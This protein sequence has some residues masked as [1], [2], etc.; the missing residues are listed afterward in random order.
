MRT[1][2]LAITSC[3]LAAACASAGSARDT[4]PASS[5]VR[6]RED[7]PARSQEAY[8]YVATRPHVV[9]ALAE[10][11]GIDDSSAHRMVDDLASRVS[12]CF[13]ALASRGELAEGAARIVL[14]AGPEGGVGG[15][16][17]RLAPGDAVT[18]NALLCV[19][20]AVK[21]VPLPAP[22][23]EAKVGMALELTWGRTTTPDP[24]G[25]AAPTTT[26]ED[27]AAEPLAP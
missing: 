18:R 3:A 20:P 26:P 16:R 27:A 17:V 12:A 1:A 15:L 8:G 22:P 25:A 2:G 11:R 23:R 4:V 6:T 21:L 13:L 7:A 24:G 5:D 9:V 19:A 14:V 10:A